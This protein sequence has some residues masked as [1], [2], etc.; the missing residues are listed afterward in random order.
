M[1]INLSLELDEVNGILGLLNQA[2]QQAQQLAEQAQSAQ[3]LFNK[4]RDQAVA[5]VPQQPVEKV[6]AEIVQ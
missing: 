3:G 5:Q 2:A 6:N 1:A 4:V